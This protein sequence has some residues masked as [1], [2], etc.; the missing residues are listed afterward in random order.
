MAKEYSCVII[1]SDEPW[2]AVWHTQLHYAWQLSMRNRVIY[3]NPPKPWKF[4]K[5]F[6]SADT[7]FSVSPQLIVVPY[8]NVLPSF[9]GKAAMFI[10][11]WFTGCRINKVLSKW[12]DVKVSEAWHFDRYRGY[13]LYRG[14]KS[15]KH[16]YHIVDPYLAEKN[17]RLFAESSDL[18]ILTSPKHLK[19]YLDINPNTIRIPQGVDLDFYKQDINSES[20]EAASGFKD[21]ILLLGTLTYDVDFEFLT[22]V[23]SRYP[24]KLLIIGPDKINNPESRSKFEKLLEVPGVNWLGPM[25][26]SDFLP[27]LKVCKVG[28]IVY[29]KTES[30]NNNLRSPLKVI[31]YLAAGKCVISNIDCEIPSLLNEAVYTVSSS[32]EYLNLID[33]AMNGNLQFNNSLVDR[34]LREVSYD[35]LLGKIYSVLGKELPPKTPNVTD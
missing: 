30:G 15:V 16:I 24:G 3:V 10:N 20:M 34:Y 4:S 12:T 6:Y 33:A 7:N 31:N 11:D 8:Q 18:V 19:H 9:L 1:T 21:S 22:T 13:F 27:Y 35:H 2:S 29:R 25:K 23:A 28:V 17:D 5:L 26:P 32:D 14:R